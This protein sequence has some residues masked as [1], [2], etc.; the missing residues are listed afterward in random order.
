MRYFKSY[1]HNLEAAGGGA[2]SSFCSRAFTPQPP[3]RKAVFAALLCCS[4]PGALRP[5]RPG[6]AAV[7]VTS[8]QPIR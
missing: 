3:A 5:V 6:A 7:G 2:P 4:P 1:F 8:E